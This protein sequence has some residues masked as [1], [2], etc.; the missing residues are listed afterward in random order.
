M[1]VVT[2]IAAA[3]GVLV[4]PSSTAFALGAVM[5]VPAAF[6]ASA[7]G[8]AS[9]VMGAPAPAPEGNQL[10]PP[11]VAG[12]KIVLRAV[13]PVLLALIGLAPIV[14]ARVAN[15]HDADP[16]A[17]AAAVGAIGVIAGG[18][19]VVWVRYR[20]ALHRALAQPARADSR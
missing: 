8:V 19:T 4:E 5:V 10:L 6:G 9:V 1:L 2:L 13:W 11:E 7:G 3:V 20:E 12:M 18:G 17:A 15:N 14:V 16:V